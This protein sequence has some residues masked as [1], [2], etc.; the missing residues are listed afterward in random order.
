MTHT[1]CACKHIVKGGHHDL[2]R[3]THARAAHIVCLDMSE[4]TDRQ[5]TILRYIDEVIEDR[6]YAPSYTEIAEAFDMTKGGAVTHVRALSTKGFVS[7]P[8]HV[9]GT[10]EILKTPQGVG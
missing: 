4:L 7:L 8:G 10:I 1:V 5:E 2:R 6:G 3:L 9:K